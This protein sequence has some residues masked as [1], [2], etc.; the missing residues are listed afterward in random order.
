MNMGTSTHVGFIAEEMR[1]LVPEVVNIE[2]DGQVG[3]IDYPSLTAVLAKAIQQIGTISDSFRTNLIAWFAQASNG[4][5]DF[6]ANRVHTK[7]ICVGEGGNETCITKTQLDALLAGAAGGGSGGGSGNGGGSPGDTTAPVLNFN[8]AAASS[9]IT[10]GSTYVDPV[11]AT[12]ETAPTN[13]DVYAS[14]NGAAPVLAG[15]LTLDTSTS[16][17]YIIDY[18]ATDTAGNVGTAQRTVEVVPQP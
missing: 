17:V 1:P 11:T 2:P 4:I 6:F 10:I 18:T 15:S 16:T 3:G 12:D 5:G 7:E 14:V 9:T 8:G 13:P